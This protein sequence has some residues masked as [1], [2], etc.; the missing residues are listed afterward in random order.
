MH[1]ASADGR[2]ASLVGNL[3]ASS[4][5]LTHL[6]LSRRGRFDHAEHGV[7][8]L[9]GQL[10]PKRGPFAKLV[11]RGSAGVGGRMAR[12]SGVSSCGSGLGRTGAHWLTDASM[13]TRLSA[14]GAGVHADGSVAGWLTAITV[15][16]GASG[17]IRGRA[18]AKQCC[19]GG[20]L[21]SAS[22]FQHVTPVNRGKTL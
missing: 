15:G 4:E 16:V 2:A 5:Q 7:M 22:C 17:P 19:R 14:V 20:E 11:P 10:L 18:H 12:M 13:A 6:S 3:A 1:F 8:E 21:D 9:F